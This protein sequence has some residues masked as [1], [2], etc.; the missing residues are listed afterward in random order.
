MTIIGP[1]SYD[2]K[3]WYLLIILAVILLLLSAPFIRGDPDT[4]EK[5]VNDLS[6]AM[7]AL[8]SNPPPQ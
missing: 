2:R 5:A 6:P 8:P 4:D 7:T 1:L 3:G